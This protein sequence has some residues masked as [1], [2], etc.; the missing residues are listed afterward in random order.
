MNFAMIIQIIEAVAELMP[1]VSKAVQAVEQAM[2]AGTPGAQK[3]DAVR[4]MIA[5]AYT[6]EQNVQVAFDQVW[7]SLQAMINMMVASFNAAGVFKK[8]TPAQ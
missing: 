5:N 4:T 7:P 2:P 1:V 6:A 3:L 8:A